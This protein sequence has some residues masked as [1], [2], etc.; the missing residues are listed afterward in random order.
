[1]ASQEHTLPEVTPFDHHA[2]NSGVTTFNVALHT[3]ALRKSRNGSTT[4]K[5]RII[6]LTKENSSL[7]HELI[8]YNEKLKT[9]TILYGSIIEAFRLLKL[10]KDV[11][12]QG[13]ESFNE[14]QAAADEA[15]CNFWNIDIEKGDIRLI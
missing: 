14:Q 9:W 2:Q 12:Q 13:L 6:E 5:E 3:P 1:M 4:D 7:R 8:R 15:L 10:A 11:L